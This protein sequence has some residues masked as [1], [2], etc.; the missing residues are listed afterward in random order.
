M[1]R[2]LLVVLALVVGE[3]TAPNAEKIAAMNNVI[4]S[5]PI[6]DAAHLVISTS[7][8]ID[9]QEMPWLDR[10]FPI[11]PG[12]YRS[13]HAD[14]IVDGK[15]LRVWTTIVACGVLSDIGENPLS[16]LDIIEKPSGGVVF[17][18]CLD[19]NLIKAVELTLKGSRSV[20]LRRWSPLAAYVQPDDA[21][22][23]A[24]LN[25]EPA[26][27]LVSITIF[28]TLDNIQW[29]T[30]YVQQDVTWDFKRQAHDQRV[31]GE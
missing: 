9:K 30:R 15:A 17:L 2:Q 19:N 21:K 10:E 31:V 16:V 24:K 22:L 8:F 12:G 28:Y 14:L 7:E 13:I 5:K 26:N 20:A 18:Y 6:G 3:L 29:Q 11:A 4:A 1:I 25:Y 23:T 27:N